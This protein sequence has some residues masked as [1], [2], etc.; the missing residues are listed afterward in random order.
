MFANMLRN[1]L[2]IIL[3]NI[4]S[5]GWATAD[6]YK[7]VDSKGVEHFSDRPPDTGK[8]IIYKND[9]KPDSRK[10]IIENRSSPGRMNDEEQ[11][12]LYRNAFDGNTILSNRA[13][14]YLLVFI[15]EGKITK[16]DI[17]Y[18]KTDEEASAV[19]SYLKT[20]DKGT[21]IN[22]HSIVSSPKPIY[23]SPESTWLIY[24]NA[25]SN[26]DMK[27]AMDCLTPASA[28]KLKKTFEVVKKGDIINIG[29]NNIGFEKVSMDS[30]RAEYRI[31]QLEKESKITYEIE[32]V[33]IFGNWKI[34]KY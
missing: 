8:A 30:S 12:R 22:I 23:S 14:T 18:I 21:K 26:Y 1:S 28:Q 11:I 32:F 2:I 13:K 4:C 24:N 6:I 10:N 16:E 17:A 29:K 20:L 7:W 19:G 3:I 31:Q 25:I 5:S 9:K 33:K 34:E 27:T 15:L